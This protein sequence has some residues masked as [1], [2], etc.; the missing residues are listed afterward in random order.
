M[1]SI[2]K[3]C[4]FVVINFVIRRRKTC[5]RLIILAKKCKPKSRSNENVIEAHPKLFLKDAMMMNDG[6]VFN[7]FDTL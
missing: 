2:T 7:N 6:K 5:S 4:I 1:K 3:T